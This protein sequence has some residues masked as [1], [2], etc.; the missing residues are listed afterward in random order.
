[1]NLLKTSLIF[2][3]ILWGK[4]SA[5]YDVS[6][7][8]FLGD[9]TCFGMKVERS[10]QAEGAFLVITTGARFEYAAG[11]LKIYQGLGSDIDRRLLA[12]MTIGDVNG[13]EKVESNGDHVL[14]WSE[15]VNIGIY[16]D[17]TCII[18]PK[19]SL[20]IKCTGS[21]KPDYEGRYK[22]ELLLID[23]LGGME[24]YPQ[25]YETG[26]K[27]KKIELGKENWVAEYTL[28][29]GERLMIAAF[30][31][32]EFDW[33]KSFKC[34]IVSTC[35][36]MGLGRGNPYGQMPSDFTI[37]RWSINFD[38]ITMFF[39]GFYENAYINGVENPSGPYIVVN[40]PEFKRLLHTSHEVNMKVVVYCSLFYYALKHKDYEA[41]YE[42]IRALRDKFG[43]D[44]VYID[45]LTFDGGGGKIDNKI[46]N[47]EMVRRFRQ[48][49]G[50][51]G[52]IVYHGT[53]LG[54]PVATVPNVDVYCDA[55]VNGEGIAFESVDDPYVR[56]QVRK[57]GISNT[58]A[59][60]EA[61]RHPNS[62]TYKDIVDATIKMNGR[63]SWGGFIVTRE[64]PPGNK[65]VWP[66]K[67]DPEYL[68]HLEQLEKLKQAYQTTKKSER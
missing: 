12:T 33:E 48:L 47:W 49:F 65:Y 61:G 31:G 57:Y 45:G 37:R 2:S 56:Y 55:T 51:D 16:G 43:I 14:F 50:S 32:R 59:L 40:E 44:G 36:S 21:F 27:V 6:S 15:K 53:H 22:G 64:P 1:M 26:Y 68:Y 24:I 7:V 67:L 23:D 54:S 9:C 17:S 28:E 4:C 66:I 3:L 35:G 25:R 42:Q 29:A 62:I 34:N 38:I 58:I 41:F 10:Y 20:D 18:I 11:K 19:V 39:Y 46:V 5:S 63:K 52:V 30:P 13:F 8:L 60:W